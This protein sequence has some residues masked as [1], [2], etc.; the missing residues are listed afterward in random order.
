MLVLV[1]F[2]CAGCVDF[3]D[4][5]HHEGVDAELSGQLLIAVR[6][7][8]DMCEPEHGTDTPTMQHTAGKLALWLQNDPELW[9]QVQNNELSGFTA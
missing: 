8:L 4:Q 5:P 2:V 1:A 9:S 3:S 7:T 6:L